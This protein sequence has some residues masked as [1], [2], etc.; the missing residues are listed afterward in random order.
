[1]NILKVVFWDVDGTIAD[2]ELN[3]HRIAFNRA[4]IDY[5]LDW[6][7]NQATYQDLLKNK[8]PVFD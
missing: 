2:T 5:D 4:F 7:W 8:I 6:N 3:G 1:M